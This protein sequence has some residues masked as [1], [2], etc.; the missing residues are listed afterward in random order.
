MY[1]LS[2]SFFYRVALNGRSYSLNM[3]VT[4]CQKIIYSRVAQDLLTALE[5]LS[6]T[7][8]R[9]S[10]VNQEDLKPYWKLEKKPY[11]SR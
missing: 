9:R 1:E 3:M 2:L 11:F 4:V 10:A 8:V 5:N 6:D 7:T